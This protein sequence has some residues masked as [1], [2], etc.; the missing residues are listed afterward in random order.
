MPLSQKI[1]ILGAI[2]PGPLTFMT[3]IQD[4]V[5]KQLFKILFWQLI[6]IAGLALVIG[7]LQGIQRGYSV[8]IGG[9]A[10]WLPT[11]IFLWRVSAHAAARAAT[12]FMVAFFAGEIGKLFVSALLFLL[13]VKYFSMDSLYGVIGLLGAIGAFWVASVSSL[14]S[15]GGGKA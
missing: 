9:L 13:A 15:S 8:L 4:A 11:L 12:R 5:R 6:I 1:I 7:F 2:F 14:L 3:K 10:Y